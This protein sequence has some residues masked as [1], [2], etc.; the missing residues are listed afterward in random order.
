VR[1]GEDGCRE[2]RGWR[3]GGDVQRLQLG[4]RCLG[5]KPHGSASPSPSCI[6]IRGMAAACPFS[7]PAHRNRRR[8]R[9]V[10]ITWPISQD[11]PLASAKRAVRLC[12][13]HVLPQSPEAVS[14]STHSTRSTRT[15]V[16]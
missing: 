1:G 14:G 8:E 4:E 10:S 2:A 3:L 15:Q 6:H 11:Q 12:H 5:N 7:L 13:I 16:L 9:A